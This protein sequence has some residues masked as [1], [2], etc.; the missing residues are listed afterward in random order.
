M[1]TERPTIT[2]LF[3]VTLLTLTAFPANAADNGVSVM[4]NAGK[5][6]C[7]SVKFV[8]K[9]RMIVDCPDGEIY[10]FCFNRETVDA[11]GLLTGTIKHFSDPTHKGLSK[12]GWDEDQIVYYIV[13]NMETADG[14]LMT[15]E[16]GIWD[17]KNKNYSGLGTVTGGTGRFENAT[18][19]L[20]AYGNT[21]GGGIGVGTVCLNN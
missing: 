11:S 13:T 2:S 9:P 16:V 6:S 4:N 1:P 20:S 8:T 14:D 17:G 10:D 18:G 15:R 12:V 5:A 21:D 19:S 3:A 7:M